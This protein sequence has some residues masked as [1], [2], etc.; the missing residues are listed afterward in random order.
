MTKTK[1]FANQ[2]RILRGPK[3]NQKPVL[4][5]FDSNKKLL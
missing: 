4:A 5:I 3:N 2:A 1:I